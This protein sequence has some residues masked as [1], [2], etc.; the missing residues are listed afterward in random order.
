M[1]SSAERFL[2]DLLSLLAIHLPARKQV[3]FEF[4]EN[5]DV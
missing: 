4:Q 3:H 2:Q 5:V 1:V